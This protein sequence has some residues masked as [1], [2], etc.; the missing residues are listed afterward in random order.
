[1]EKECMN[2]KCR[3]KIEEKIE[4]FS[5][6]QRMTAKKK[7]FCWYCRVIEHLLQYAKQRAQVVF[8]L[9]SKFSHLL[10]IA[11]TVLEIAIIIV[12]R[13]SRC[14]YIFRTM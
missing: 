1:M 10:L 14:L 2:G 11:Q 6:T 9:Y 13:M 12:V 4:I 5:E 8:S 7:R 3:E